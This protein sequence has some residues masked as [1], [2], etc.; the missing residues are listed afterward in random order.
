MTLATL[1]TLTPHASEDLGVGTLI[2]TPS[3]PLVVV[4]TPG[5]AEE[6]AAAHTAD[7]LSDIWTAHIR[8]EDGE[9][10]RRVA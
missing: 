8:R 1:A 6:I 4:E 5:L 2:T 7:L 9:Q 10:C 3:G